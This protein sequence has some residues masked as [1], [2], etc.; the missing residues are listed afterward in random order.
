MKYSQNLRYRLKDI[1]KSFNIIKN[2][3]TELVI[4]KWMTEYIFKIFKLPEAKRHSIFVCC[5]H[6]LSLSHMRVESECV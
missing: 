6:D 5:V 3:F 2:W 1:M 4:R